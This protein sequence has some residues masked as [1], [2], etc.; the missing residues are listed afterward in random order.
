MEVI[1]NKKFDTTTETTDRV[2]E[3]A[4][5]FG[6]GLEDKEFVIYKNLKLDIKDD[7]IVYINGQSGSGKSILLY[8][9]EKELKKQGKKICNINDVEIKDEPLIE[10]VCDNVHEAL[11]LLSKVGLNDAYLLIRKPKELSD[12][13]KYRF[14][15]AKLLEKNADVWIADEFGA[16]LDRTTAKVVAFNIQ[17]IARQNKKMLIVATTHT[18]LEEE[19]APNLTIFKNYQDKIDISRLN[20]D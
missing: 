10:Q 20:S 19:L 16:V 5:A 17:K 1:I 12:G 7:D 14:R 18:D 15:L 13:Q 6:L 8:E 3:I 4:E 11:N 2:L 9:L